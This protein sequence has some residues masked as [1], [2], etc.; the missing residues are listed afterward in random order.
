MTHWKLS[1]ESFLILKFSSLL[2]K[3]IVISKRNAYLTGHEKGI[4]LYR[5]SS[6]TKQKSYLIAVEASNRNRRKENAQAVLT[7]DDKIHG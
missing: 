2:N 5:R 3:P 1:Q 6:G 7:I 4:K